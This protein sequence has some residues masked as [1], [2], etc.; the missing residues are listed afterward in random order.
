KPP[1]QLRVDRIVDYSASARVICLSQLD[2]L[3]SRDRLQDCPGFL[4]NLLTMREV[5]GVVVRDDA[6]QRSEPAVQWSLGEELGDVAHLLAE[7]LRPL[8][9]GRLGMEQLPV[10]LH[11]RA[12]PRRV[13]HDELPVSHLADA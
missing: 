4:P 2:E 10:L 1:V 13:D 11:D 3:E 8:R 12:A 5:A 6:L 7:G 9:V